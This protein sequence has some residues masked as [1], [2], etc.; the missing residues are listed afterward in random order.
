MGENGEHEVSSVEEL[1]RALNRV[2][3]EI[4]ELPPEAG[5]PA[6]VG[7]RAVSHF[8]YPFTGCRDGGRDSFV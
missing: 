4:S 6:D 2:R 7:R 5:V 1:D 8:V 3:G